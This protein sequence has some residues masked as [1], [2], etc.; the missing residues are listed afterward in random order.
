MNISP[1]LPAIVIAL[2]AVA[3]SA[4]AAD[5]NADILARYEPRTY[6]DAAG[7]TLLY[8]LA[9]PA[10]FDKTKSY[11][12]VL[13]LHGA[14]GRGADNIGQIRDASPNT[15]AKFALPKHQEKFPCFIVAPQCPPDRKWVDVDWAAASHTMPAKPTDELRMV[16]EVLE[17]LRKEFPVDGRRI[18]V[19][20]LSMGGYGTWDV[21]ARH[22]NYFAA[23]AP[24]C[25]GG[26]EAT[27][28][29]I[30]A[31]PIWCFHGG[32]DGVVKPQRS[33]NMIEAIKKAGGEPKY[34]EYPNEGHGSWTPAY[35]E[36]EFL[37]WLF[38]QKLKQDPKLD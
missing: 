38:A 29:R 33:R 32:K 31:I 21:I 19:T 7:K 35:N 3:L 11:P 20:G 25:G 4:R 10:D 8:R 37:P 26:D 22:P 12:L 14:G 1:L 9:K 18:Y 16:V 30:A 5:P 2:A 23:A 27:A 36:A 24:I 15:A 34:T 6:T 17:Q 13:F 28:G